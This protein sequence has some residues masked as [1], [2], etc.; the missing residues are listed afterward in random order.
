MSDDLSDISAS[1]G[2]GGGAALKPGQPSGSWIGP[3]DMVSVI[4]PYYNRAET[5]EPAV[6]SVLNQT[7][8]HLRLYL[9]NDGST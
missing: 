7:H 9:I 6:M 5:L 2:P 3:A 8:T 1:P 4:L